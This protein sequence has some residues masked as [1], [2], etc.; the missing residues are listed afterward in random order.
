[1]IAESCLWAGVSFTGSYSAFQRASCSSAVSKITLF[2]AAKCLLLRL[3]YRDETHKVADGD[4]ALLRGLREVS[5]A[6]GVRPN[7]ER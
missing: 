6:F 1:M 3:F 5:L 7:R 2:S 4:T